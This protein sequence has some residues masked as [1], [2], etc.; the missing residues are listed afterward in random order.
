[1]V[2]AK[3]IREVAGA[4]GLELDERG[5]AR[6][7]TPSCL[8]KGGGAAWESADGLTIPKHGTPARG[9]WDKAFMGR[10]R[11][12]FPTTGRRTIKVPVASLDQR[13]PPVNG[14]R[15]EMYS[16]MAAADKLPPIVV[17]RRGQRWYVVDG[18]HR[19][20]AAKQQGLTHLDAVELQAPPR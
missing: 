1:M 13:N 11:E 19:M 15:L 5:D 18:N 4:A 12:V 3:K 2:L 7:T 20:N 6:M 8:E 14:A 9:R 16:Q 17:E 10:V